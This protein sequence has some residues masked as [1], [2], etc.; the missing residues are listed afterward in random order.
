MQ[1]EGVFRGDGEGGFYEKMNLHEDGLCWTLGDALG[2][3][4]AILRRRRGDPSTTLCVDDRAGAGMYFTVCCPDRGE[5]E[6]PDARG[7]P[8]TD[9]RKNGR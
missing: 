3:W 2:T 4:S 1:V 6:A 8:R 7:G 9:A 5:N